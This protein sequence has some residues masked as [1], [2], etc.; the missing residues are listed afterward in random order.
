MSARAVRILILFFVTLWIF[1]YIG[2]V[3]GQVSPPAPAR[4]IKVCVL[5]DL[6]SLADKKIITETLSAVF[7]EYEAKT[8][9]R[10]EASTF[11]SFE[12]DPTAPMPVVWLFARMACL[13]SDEVRIIFTNRSMTGRD[14]EGY[15]IEFLGR[16]NEDLGVVVIYAVGER[17][18]LRDNGGNL[19]LETSLKH[20]LAHLFKLQH[21]SDRASFMYSP[22]NDSYGMWTEGIFKNI[23]KNK[24]KRWR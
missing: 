3:S 12:G 10:F 18:P 4:V 23:E 20:E 24:D 7:S 22:S 14:E 13:A 11:A 16:S 1:S 21:T 2:V 15:E 17:A 9:I 6:T 5:N 19:A 8:R